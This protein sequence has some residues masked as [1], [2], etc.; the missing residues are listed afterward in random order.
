[1]TTY[2]TTGEY[3]LQQIINTTHHTSRVV[4]INDNNTTLTV[5]L[6]NDFF[7][8]KLGTTM[9]VLF[10]PVFEP[11][12]GYN[13]GMHGR[14]FYVGTENIYISFGGLMMHVH[15]PVAGDKYFHDNKNTYCFFKIS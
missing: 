2:T 1:M 3:T 7:N 4:G 11:T 12:S 6:H 10:S 13:Y 8:H 15:G 9:S 14:I 5:D